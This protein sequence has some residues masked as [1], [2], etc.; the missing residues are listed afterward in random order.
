MWEVS[1]VILKRKRTQTIFIAKFPLVQSSH[2]CLLT[3][4]HQRSFG[5]ATRIK[6][7]ILLKCLF[8]FMMSSDNNKNVQKSVSIISVFFAIDSMS[9]QAPTMYSDSCTFIPP[10]DTPMFSLVDRAQKKSV[11]LHYNKR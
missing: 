10:H 5:T 1:C 7:Q 9:H 11:I 6:K 2:Y 3:A 8:P 4:I